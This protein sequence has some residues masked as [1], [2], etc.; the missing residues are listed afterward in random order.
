MFYRTNFLPLHSVDEFSDCELSFIWHVKPV[1]NVR[2]PISS[3]NLLGEF[4]AW[5]FPVQL[6]R[7]THPLLPR[8]NLLKGIISQSYKSNLIQFPRI[9]SNRSKNQFA[10]VQI[11][12][13]FLHSLKCIS[14][15]ER[16]KT[17][18]RKRYHDIICK[19]TA[20]SSYKIDRPSLACIIK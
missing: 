15:G 17:K 9:T 11:C 18:K 19:I 16:K 7:L 5:G 10:R 4:I 20:H 1:S 3:F 8:A 12:K 2:L 6:D 13:Q 14:F